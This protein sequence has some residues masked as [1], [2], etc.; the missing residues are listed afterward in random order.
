MI[1]RH[2]VYRFATTLF[3]TSGSSPA[4]T[5]SRRVAGSERRQVRVHEGR[6]FALRL[7]LGGQAGPEVPQREPGGLQGLQ[8]SASFKSSCSDPSSNP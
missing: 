4:I 3:S 7:S 6:V 8:G 1:K 2:E 5:G